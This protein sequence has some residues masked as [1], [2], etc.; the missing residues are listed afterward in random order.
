MSS[1]TIGKKLFLGTGALVASAFGIAAFAG[2]SGMGTVCGPSR[3]RCPRV[4]ERRLDDNAHLG[5]RNYNR[6]GDNRCQS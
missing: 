5:I 3:T 1:I 6:S 2:Q 4:V